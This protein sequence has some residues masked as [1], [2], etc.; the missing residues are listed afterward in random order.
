M[1]LQCSVAWTSPIDKCG[2]INFTWRGDN[3]SDLCE[4]NSCSEDSFTLIRL[5]MTV[6]QEEN[7]TAGVSAQC[8]MDH[9]KI[10]V[11]MVE[12]EAV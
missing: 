7:V 5:T 1:T 8:G 6:W 10:G 12:G 11:K 3:N 9:F 2:S 4:K